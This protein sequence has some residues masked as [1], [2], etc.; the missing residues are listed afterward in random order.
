MSFFSYHGGFGMLFQPGNAR[1]TST[2]KNGAT[3]LEAW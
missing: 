1:L 2:Q 3:S